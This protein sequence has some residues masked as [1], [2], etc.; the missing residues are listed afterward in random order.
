MISNVGS[1]SGDQITFDVT[2]Y[3]EDE[4]AVWKTVATEKDGEVT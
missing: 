1:S 3:D 2:F 4:N